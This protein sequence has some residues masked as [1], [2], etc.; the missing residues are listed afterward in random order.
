MASPDEDFTSLPLTERLVHKS[1]KARQG[2]YDEL[3]KM[4]STTMDPDDDNAFRKWTEYLKKMVNDANLVAQ[5]S[6]L[7]ALLAY[8]QNAPSALRTR[9]NISPILVDKCLGSNRAGTKARALDVLLTYIELDSTGDAVIEDITAGLSHKTP[10]TVVGAAAAMREALHSFGIKIINVKPILKQLSKLF[11]HKDKSVRAEGTALAVELYRWLGPAINNSLSDLKPVQIKELQDTFANLPAERAMPTRLIRSEQAKVQSAGPVEDQTVDQGFVEEDAAQEPEPIDPYDLADPINILDK[12]PK[13]FYDQL[14]STK[15]K[16]RKEA[17][18]SLLEILK[19]PKLEDGRYGELVSALGKRIGDANLLVGIASANCIEAIARGLRGSFAQYRTLVVSPLLEKLK[20]KKQHVVDALRG[21]LDA[22]YESVSIDDVVETIVGAAAHKNPQ[23]RAETLQWL[24]RCLKNTKKPPGKA[25][26]KALGEMLVKAVEDS[27]DTV[28]EAAAEAFGTLMKVAGERAMA[29][30]LEGV[31][32][33][34]QE[35]V[36]EYY[37][38]AEVKASN[39]P[40]R[41]PGGATSA[42]TVRRRGAPTESASDLKTT[43]A[44]VRRST[45]SSGAPAKPS[46]PS[47]MKPRPA[48]AATGGLRKK[49]TVGSS[50]RVDVA[51]KS[52]AA[53]EPITFRFTEESAEAAMIDLVGEELMG[54]LSDPAWKI[55]LAA[56]QGILEKLKTSDT[57]TIAPEAVACALNKKPGW[58]ESNF[59]VM[60]TLLQ[61]FQFLAAEVPRFDRSAGT[62]ITPPIAEK[63]GDMKVK[64][65]AGDCMTAI[66]EKLSLQFVLGHVYEVMKKQKSPKIIADGLIWI[67]QSLLEFGT[68]GVQL[69]ELVEFLKIALA[70]TNQAV[71]NNAVIVMGTLRMYIGPDVRR[72]VEDLSPQ[73]LATLDAEFEK[74]AAKAPPKPMKVQQ[75]DTSAASADPADD[76]FPRVDISSQVTSLLIDDLG[77]PQWKVRGEAIEELGKILEATNKRIEP[78]LPPELVPALKARLTD[79]NKNIVTN[80]VELIGNFALA[81]GKPFERYSKTLVGSLASVLA[82]QKA[83]VRAAALTAMDNVYSVVGIE[84]MLGPCAAALMTEQPILR[85]HLLQWLSQKLESSTEGLPDMNPLVHPILLCL[86]DKITDVRQ[87]AKAILPFVGAKVGWDVIVQRASDLFKGTALA[88]VMGFL[89]PYKQ[90]S[91]SRASAPARTSPKGSRIA[92]PTKT[93]RSTSV[94]PSNTAADVDGGSKIRMSAMGG[95]RLRLP[96]P[97]TVVAKKE[98]LPAP[99][100]ISCPFTSADEREKDKRTAADRG[101]NKWTFDVPRRELVDFLAEQAASCVDPAVHKLMFSTDHYKEKEYLA[102]LTAIDDPIAGGEE[103]IAVAASQ[104]GIDAD[105]FV[106]RYVINADIILKYITLRFFDTNTSML[107]KLLDLLEHL[108]ALLDRAGYHMTEYE[109]SSFLPFFIGKTGDPKEVMRA[110][111]RGIMKLIVRLYPASKLFGYLLKGLEAKNVRTRIEC[112]EEL[113]SL[114]Q[115]NGMNVCIP[116]KAFPQIAG[117]LGDR[118]A[119]VRNG[120]LAAITQ[121]YLLIGEDIYKYVGRLSEKDKSLIAE[122]LKRVRPAVA[123]EENHDSRG[124]VASNA[125]S[126]PASPTRRPS[127]P[128]KS[129]SGV[130]ASRI[131]RVSASSPTRTEPAQ[132]SRTNS[133]TEKSTRERQYFN[134][135]QG[136]RHTMHINGKNHALITPRFVE[137]PEDTRLWQKIDQFVSAETAVPPMPPSQVPVDTPVLLPVADSFESCLERI[138]NGDSKEATHWSFQMLNLYDQ[139]KDDIT[140]LVPEVLAVC[141]R[142]LKADIS[143]FPSETVND[144]CH[145][146]VKMIFQIFCDKDLAQLV[147][148]NQV[149][150]LW[151]ILLDV[152]LDPLVRDGKNFDG[153]RSL[154]EEVSHTLSKSILNVQK[155]ACYSILL[156]MLGSETQQ[157][158]RASSAEETQRPL[159][160]IGGISKCIW[161]RA[162]QKPGIVRDLTHGGLR[163]DKLLMEV[164]KLL[165]I[166]SSNDWKRMAEKYGEQ[167]DLAY[168]TVKTLVHNI[169][170]AAKNSGNNSED[171]L[172][173]IPKEERHETTATWFLAKFE[174]SKVDKPA[175]PFGENDE[176]MLRGSNGNL[177][178]ISPPGGY[179]L[180]GSPA[181][182]RAMFGTSGVGHGS[183]TEI[184]TGSLDAYGPSVQAQTELQS[185]ENDTIPHKSSSTSMSSQLGGSRL[186]RFSSGLRTTTESRLSRLREP[187]HD[188]SAMSSLPTISEFKERVWMTQKRLSRSEPSV[189][190]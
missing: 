11:D 161:R 181:P 13:N 105:E 30:H 77:S 142:R 114:V 159:V 138:K 23:V 49:P 148:K 187:Q 18:E 144:L 106:S 83:H 158:A 58:K 35:K 7:G 22:V 16:E 122:R 24:V 152:Y 62:I 140:L 94:I 60:T 109:A 120:A 108:F 129:Q 146:I 6:G 150:E 51:K 131:G 184:Q 63:L 168:R 163:G 113:A 27:V 119:G 124:S 66:A 116:S 1:W 126:P 175:N 20:E 134:Y 82:D 48:Q 88:T 56:M 173:L 165:R 123:V 65:V 42:A 67:Q 57:S 38:K 153:R 4:F 10:K 14:A 189:I 59:Q 47:T 101:M 85:Q 145:N 92:T 182:E 34:K 125:L 137:P 26:V 33:L 40:I 12:I 154:S 132:L 180:A 136:M 97:G 162:K 3:A 155:D 93:R 9:S 53:L 110:K 130:Y 87:G 75:L 190:P 25:E 183:H 141:S 89:E 98:A 69:R 186:A 31:A 68:T 91:I 179:S 160:R 76:L 95:S 55:R 157:L 15:W 39:N 167:M 70:N 156:G 164:H 112:L 37:E 86:Q 46:V 176:R 45:V 128:A 79:N 41:K 28:R 117:Q 90:S 99:K 172:N 81:M 96:R 178:N 43:S 72:F 102:A 54:Q 50:A 115:R 127:S 61:T 171:Y 74:A 143:F 36:K 107:L 133:M 19:A 139:Q 2:A 103:S 177:G 17:L 8:V 5:E 80:A 147:S 174:T 100:E 169:S 78:K 118:D 44:P 149:I 64:R 71:R 151:T 166:T 188:T 104:C 185:R 170:V 52:T 29:A 73:L 121:A 32:N 84:S 21:A 111:M 135:E